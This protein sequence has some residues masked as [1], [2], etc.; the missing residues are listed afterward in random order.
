M[1]SDILKVLKMPLWICLPVFFLSLSSFTCAQDNLTPDEQATIKAFEKVSPAVA[2]IVNAALKKDVFSLNVTEVPTGTGS[3]FIWDDEGHIVTNFHVILN[4]DRISVG[5]SDKKLYKATIVGVAPDYDLAVLKVDAPKEALKTVTLGNSGDLKV[6]QKALSIGNPFGLDCSLSTGVISALGRSMSSIGGRQIH[7]VIQTDASINPGN[8]GGPLLDSTGNVI[9]VST[10]I[11]SPS[12]ASAGIGFA[13]PV[14][15]VKKVVPQLIKY[16]KLK[17]V[18]LG[19]NLVPDNIR[20]QL[21]IKGVMIMQIQKGST[22]E[23]AGFRGTQR[24]ALGELVYGDV[25][26]SVDKKP[27]KDNESLMQYFDNKRA[28]D[29]VSIEFMREGNVMQTTVILQEL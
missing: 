21:G 29:K 18:G 15:V 26:I 4:A 23:G 16:G 24:G 14:S 10:M 19:L 11:F 1:L 8:S 22:A 3:G 6:G 12:G 20:Q 7:D 9:G 17:K 13:I 2:Y 28:G 27:I 25:I 5:L